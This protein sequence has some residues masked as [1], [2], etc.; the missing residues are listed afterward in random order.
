MNSINKG[1]E[2]L[3]NIQVYRRTKR[4]SWVRERNVVVQANEAE[5]GKERG[6][7]TNPIKNTLGE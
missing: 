1:K 7:Q 3:G 5:E 4:K 6:N 2:I